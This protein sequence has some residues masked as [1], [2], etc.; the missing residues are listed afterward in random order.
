MVSI[1][2]RPRKARDSVRLGVNLREALDVAPDVE[3]GP[4]WRACSDRRRFSWI[5]SPRN[6][7]VIWNER[8]EPLLADRVRLDAADRRAVQ[9]HAALVRRVQAGDDD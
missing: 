8:A 4:G 7:L 6:R 3:A 5:E 9:A 2:S 1:P